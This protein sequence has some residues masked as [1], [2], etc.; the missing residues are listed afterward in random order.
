M[1]QL[2]LCGPRSISVY[3][4]K[5]KKW[6]NAPPPPPP[7][8]LSLTYQSMRGLTVVT[9]LLLIPRALTIV[10]CTV[11]KIEHFLLSVL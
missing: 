3:R 6:L 5:S 10:L 2:F 8:P 11:S 1:A 4:S 7:P 9:M